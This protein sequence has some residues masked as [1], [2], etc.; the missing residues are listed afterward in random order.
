ML[1]LLGGDKPWTMEKGVPP[2]NEKEG[3]EKIKLSIFFKCQVHKLAI[4]ISSLQLLDI[5]VND[6]KQLKHE[7]INFD[8]LKI[9]FT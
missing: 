7:R 8:F 6:F 5:Y 3:Y 9:F 1:N 2:K 4:K